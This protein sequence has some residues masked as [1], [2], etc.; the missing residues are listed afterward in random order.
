V[1]AFGWLTDFVDC[2]AFSLFLRVGF[3]A[4]GAVTTTRFDLGFPRF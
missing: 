4:F 3:L 2:R 1:T